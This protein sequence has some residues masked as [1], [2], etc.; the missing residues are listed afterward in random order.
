MKKPAIRVLVLISLGLGVGIMGAIL[1]SVP[2]FLHH[3]LLLIFLAV[4]L[5]SNAAACNIFAYFGVIRETL[6]LYLQK[7]FIK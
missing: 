5:I 2:F 3:K 6:Q 4:L 7:W 1:A